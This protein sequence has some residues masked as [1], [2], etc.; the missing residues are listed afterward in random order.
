MK[1]GRY[2]DIISVKQ[3]GWEYLSEFDP[4]QRDIIIQYVESGAA[5]LTTR[6]SGYAG[7]PEH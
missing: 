5:G 4:S 7:L 1:K 3:D 6:L 2:E